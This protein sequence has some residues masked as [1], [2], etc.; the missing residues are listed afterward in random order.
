VRYVHTNL[1]ARDWRRLAAFYES[2]FLCQRVLPERRL[3]G[4]SMARGSGVDGA[5]LEGAHLRLPGWGDDGPTLEIFQYSEHTEAP[6]PVA[7]RV[8]FGHIAFAVDD[9]G[10]ARAAVLAAGGT[11]VGT[12]ETLTIPGAGRITWT[13][14]RDPEGNIVELQRRER[15]TTASAPFSRSDLLA[16]MRGELYAVQATVSANGAPQA[17]LVGIVVSDRFEIFFDTLGTSRKAANLRSG[18]TAALVI[19][20]TAADAVR[21]VQCEGVA[22]EPDG[23]DLERLL[24]AYFERFPDGRARRSLPDIMYVRV[25]PTWLRYSDFSVHPP[26]IVTFRGVDLTPVS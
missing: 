5:S 19:G 16:F 23:A 13:Y 7:N 2:V 20:P 17:A 4:E 18:S 8:G 11:A 6:L 14:V 3:S 22:D 12:V 9:V 21:T 26:A 1:I 10:A 24:E 25:S 15:E